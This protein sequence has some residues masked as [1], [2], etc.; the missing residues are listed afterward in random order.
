[1]CAVVTT[2]DPLT[3]ALEDIAA[4]RRVPGA[5]YRLQ[6][7]Q[8]FT[9]ADAAGVVDYLADLGISDIMPRRCCARAR[10]ARTAMTSA[11]TST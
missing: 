8:S 7:S 2:H 5:T 1:M 4:R 11:I 6:F 9:F 3:E 10:A